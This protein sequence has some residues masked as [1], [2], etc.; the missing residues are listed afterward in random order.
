MQ[1]LT[2]SPLLKV[3]GWALFNSLWQ[4]ALLWLSYSILI[5]VFNNIASQ[6]RYRLA[7]VF[8]GIGTIWF[9]VTLAA[10]W[11]FPVD[12]IATG[13][14]PFLSPAPGT[15]G[16]LWQT[17][18]L[19]MDDILPYGS[20]L[21]LLALGG[22]LTRYF[23][24]YWHS[25]K[26]NRQGL[27]KLPPEFRVF[28]A[29]TSRSMGIH[30]PV[31]A[32]LSSLVDVPLTLGFLKPV[33]LLPITMVSHLTPQQ[34]EAILVHE[35][36]H[37]RRKDYL[38]HLVATLVDGLF[39]FNPFSRLLIRQL[40]KEREHCCD[41]LVLQFRYDPRSYVSALL[42]LATN[43]RQKQLLAIAA[44]GEG[45]R[46][47]L[48]RA[49]RILHQKSPGE[50]PGA[51]P[52]VVLIFTLLTTL[53]V[54]HQPAHPISGQRGQPVTYYR[55]PYRLPARGIP[56][57]GTVHRTGYLVI[58]MPAEPATVQLVT[59]PLKKT[60]KAFQRSD[61]RI[62][63]AAHHPGRPTVYVDDA[64]APRPDGDE[65]GT[66]FLNTASDAENP[67]SSAYTAMLQAQPDNKD[68][69]FVSPQIAPLPPAGTFSPDGSPFV[70]QSSFT[71]LYTDDSSRAGEKL[72]YLKQLTQ[73][74]MLAAIN[75]AD[76]ELAIRLKDLSAQQTKENESA[77]G[78]RQ[79]QQQQIILQQQYLE[80]LTR[81]Q[82]KLEK[83]GHF[84]V[85]V[86][87]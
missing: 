18:R 31:T 56:P 73:Q 21:Y 25:R 10:A 58:K 71:F 83:I 70:P 87:I 28:V 69:S 51:R 42:S 85:I 7:L 48:Q 74:E 2:Q 80:K 32:W 82:K 67:G 34:V 59:V 61:L 50:R 49:K 5:S 68:F 26:L 13:W 63:I 75:R 4:M 52:L 66:V 77:K 8:L 54:T 36:A 29:A 81:W 72:L 16:R 14:P 40:K 22:L 84:K 65:D 27:S 33:I 46:M 76:H 86:H 57:N 11:F 12:L 64:F 15:P 53:I 41:D 1:L 24:H 3:L 20:T 43:G 17:T 37:I 60:N 62:R 19:L 6:I 78:R 23:A 55:L 39:F 45:D 47:L 38:L 9:G 30:T 44:T 79:L 35:L